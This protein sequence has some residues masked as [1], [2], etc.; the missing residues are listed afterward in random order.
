MIIGKLIHNWQW[1]EGS[2]GWVAT[3]EVEQDRRMAVRIETHGAMLQPPEGIDARAVLYH[4]IVQ[5]EREEAELLK[6]YYEEL[7]YPERLRMAL[8]ILGH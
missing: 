8:E 6:E 3:V 7:T 5:K 1:H 4:S 2:Q